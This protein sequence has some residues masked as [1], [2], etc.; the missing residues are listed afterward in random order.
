MLTLIDFI[1]IFVLILMVGG[2]LWYIRKEK[3][4]GVKC[5]GCPAAGTCASRNKGGCSS[6]T[7][8]TL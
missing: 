1:I 7:D 2:A 5:I 3:K 8:K 6:N 4:R